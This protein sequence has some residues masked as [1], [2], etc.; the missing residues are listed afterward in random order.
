MYSRGRE[1]VSCSLRKKRKEE[2][3]KV[4]HLKSL[5]TA[6]TQASHRPEF[7]STLAVCSW[8]G[9]SVSLSL[10]PILQIRNLILTPQC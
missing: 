4:K 10:I 9:H 8:A 6:P 5:S 7:S 2:L 3:R 1:K